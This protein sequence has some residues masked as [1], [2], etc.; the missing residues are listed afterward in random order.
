MAAP[1]GRA[2]STP[3]PTPTH[4]RRWPQPALATCWGSIVP[5]LLAQSMHPFL[6]ASAAVWLHALESGLLAEDLPDSLPGIMADRV[7]Q[8]GGKA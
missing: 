2:S 8:I 6:A 7:K 4:R 1:D 3:T 5:G